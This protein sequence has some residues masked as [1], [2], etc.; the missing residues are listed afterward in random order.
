MIELKGKYGEG[1]YYNPSDGVR[2]QD[3]FVISQAISLLNEP[4]SKESNLRL[5]PD[6][7]VG[8]G[9]TVGTTMLIRDKASP[10]LVGV[11]IGC[12][13]ALAKFQDGSVDYQKLDRAIKMA[14]PRG[15]NIHPMQIINFSLD[16]LRMPLS[17]EDKERA[18]KSLG[19]LGGGN[20]YIEAGRSTGNNSLYLSVH[21]GSRSLGV[22]VATYYQNLAYKTLQGRKVDK[23]RIIKE[24]K[25]QGKEKNIEMVLRAIEPE[26]VNKDMAYLEGT[27]LED[28]LHDMKICTEYAAL[29][30]RTIIKLIEEA[31]G[32]DLTFML[33][34][35]HNYIDVENRILR[36]GSVSASKG[37]VFI[38]PLNMR[39]GSLICKG[40]GNPDWNFSAPHGA[41]RKMSR[42][43]AKELVN[44][45]DYKETME[46]IY[47]S[48]VNT[49][50]LDESPF[51]YK[52]SY[53]LR[54]AITPTA[55]I[56]DHLRVEY[57]CKD[58]KN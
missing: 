58:D 9:C 27:Y 29:N 6:A 21:S 56:M 50:T 54:E 2:E 15:F 22:R 37:E 34:T 13:V 49:N 42:T 53:A 48:T 55:E 14:V 12:G 41:G 32:Y 33:D 24:L 5:M 19:T 40:K 1:I 31:S 26:L 43:K 57:N 23:T 10:N 45:E 38:L 25:E 18:L 39:D 44:L 16:E 11:D 47:S 3:E 52:N 28:Y 20:H 36:K 8:K 46:G 7:H 35:V 17:D 51:A 30:R 4:F